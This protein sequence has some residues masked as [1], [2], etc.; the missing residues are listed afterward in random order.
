[1]IFKK[2]FKPVDVPLLAEVTKR[3]RRLAQDNKR[4][5]ADNE[6]LIAALKRPVKFKNP[7]TSL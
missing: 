5:L 6:R 4:L 2:H 1:M 3:Q 7:P